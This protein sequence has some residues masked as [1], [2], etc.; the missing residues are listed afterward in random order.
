[1]KT[2]RIRAGNV[3]RNDVINGQRIKEIVKY[4]RRVRSKGD[5]HHKLESTGVIIIAP[6]PNGYRMDVFDL[7]GDEFINVKRPKYNMNRSR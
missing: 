6:N 4:G 5:I 1:M 7:R 2:V 3:R